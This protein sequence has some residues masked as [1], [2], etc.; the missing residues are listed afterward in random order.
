MTGWRPLRTALFFGL[1]GPFIGAALLLVVVEE[2]A[3]GQRA[4]QSSAL[5]DLLI[6]GYVIG[7]PPML[8]IGFLVA[9]SAQ[10]GKSFFGLIALAVILGVVFGALSALLWVFLGPVGVVPSFDLVAA[11]AI[12]GGAAGFGCTLLLGLR[13]LFRPRSAAR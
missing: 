10:R 11:L 2:P 4:L 6:S 8:A 12:A 5:L 13:S 9:T 3:A 7:L 1:V